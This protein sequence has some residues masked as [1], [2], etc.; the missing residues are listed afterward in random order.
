MKIYQIKSEGVTNSRG[1]ELPIGCLYE[2]D[3]DMT[4]HIK[5]GAVVET[6]AAKLSDVVEMYNGKSKGK[7]V[8]KRDAEAGTNV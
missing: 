1:R 4:N 5:S 8:E 2:T 3:A 6:K 7:K